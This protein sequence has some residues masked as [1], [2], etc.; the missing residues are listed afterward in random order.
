MNTLSKIFT[1]FRKQSTLP[2]VQAYQQW[3]ANY[4]ATAHNLLMQVEH[5]AMLNLMPEVKE[6]RVLDL[7]SG[8][9]RW[10]Q[11]A[12]TQ[13]ANIVIGCDN[14]VAMLNHSALIYRVLATVTA[15]PLPSASI[16]IILYGLA[17]G[18]SQTLKDVLTEVSRVLSIG[19]VALISDFHP[20][21]AWQGAQRTFQGQDGKTYAVEH[22]V[23][24]YADWFAASQ[25]AGLRITGVE[26]PH[27]PDQP[28]TAPIVFVLR[29]EKDSAMMNP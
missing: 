20:A 21:L 22:Y 28:H 19:G 17:V 2:S 15:I 16:D 6:R 29:L 3:A 23:H 14:S 10:G 26:E 27:R 4:P 11:W 1:F 7:A 18:H 12:S 8:T 24:R 5:T 25:A 9:G 13:G